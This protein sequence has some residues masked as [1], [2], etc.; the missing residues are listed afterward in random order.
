MMTL[1][2][3]GEKQEVGP[4]EEVGHWGHDLG[5]CIL[6]WPLPVFPYYV[7]YPP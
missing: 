4:I 2:G 6:P 3:G 1:L 5:G 7:S